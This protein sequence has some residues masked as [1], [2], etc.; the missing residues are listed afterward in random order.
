MAAVRLAV[1]QLREAQRAA[2]LAQPEVREVLGAGAAALRA[3]HD[4][5]EILEAAATVELP[6]VEGPVAQEAAR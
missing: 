6:A 3:L 5:T 2:W 4:R 1:V